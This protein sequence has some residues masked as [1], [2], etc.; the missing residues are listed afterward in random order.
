MVSN[1]KEKAAGISQSSFMELKAM[2]SE[3]KDVA[4]RDKAAGKS[5]YIKGRKMMD[6]KLSVWARENKDVQKRAAR[7]LDSEQLDKKAVEHYTVNMKRKAELY[8][9]LHKGDFDHLTDKQFDN[10]L[11]DVRTLLFV[12]EATYLA[13]LWQS[14]FTA[15]PPVEFSSDSDDD[16]DESATVPQPPGQ[17]DPVIEYED[18][19][20]RVRSAPRS[21]VPP[22]LLPKPMRRKGSDDGDEGIVLEN[23][24]NFFPVYEPTADRVAAIQEAAA[25]E[26]NPLNV[27]YDADREVRAKGAGFYQF[28]GDEETR[29]KQME[30]LKAAREET[31]KKRSATGAVDLKPGAPE[32]M[33]EGGSGGSR[34]MDERKRKLEERR[35]AIEAKRRKIT[36]KEDAPSKTSP[37][38][39]ST[40]TPPAVSS[41]GTGS[42]PPEPP[43]PA[44]PFAQLEAQASRPS[45][46]TG[47][48][49]QDEATAWLENLQRDLASR[50]GR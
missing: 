31:E 4:S 22:H 41:P 39:P 47:A 5:T 13:D 15:K 33:Q 35:R 42:T 49:P 1:K 11:V 16:E 27:H 3:R 40:S 29:Q 21:Q 30:E 46:K 36:G 19:F 48:A 10:L 34:A 23:P 8:D 14:Q 7:D 25:E 17:D 50:K 44:D 26:N 38:L 9:R 45:Q 12:P 18:E 28:S 32:G 43:A 20:G 2:V 37:P 6:K 24:A